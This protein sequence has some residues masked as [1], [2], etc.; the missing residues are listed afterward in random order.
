MDR[1]VLD[2]MSTETQAVGEWVEISPLARSDIQS[3]AAHYAHEVEHGVA[4]FDTVIPDA[5]YW[6]QKLLA[7]EAGAYPVWVARDTRSQDKLMGWAGVSR[8]D[9]KLAYRRSAEFSFYVLGAYQGQGLGR[10]LLNHVV[11]N[12]KTHP[13]IETL[14]S[15]IALQQEASLYLHRAAGFQHVGTLRDVGFKLGGSL[16][17]ALYQLMLEPA[18]VRSEGT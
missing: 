2:R 12:L 13:T 10:A 17:V 1:E 16:S 3:V 15:R 5:D 8:F 6:E 11:G 9:P 7:S 4:T 18:G 14:V